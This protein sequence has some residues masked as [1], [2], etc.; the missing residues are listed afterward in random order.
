MPKV[1]SFDVLT[2]EQEEIREDDDT[3]DNSDHGEVAEEIVADTW[4]LLEHT[5]N[6]EYWYDV[7]A[8]LGSRSTKGEVKSAQLHVGQDYPAEGRFRIRKDQHDSLVR[9]DAQATAWYFF[10]VF[11]NS[12]ERIIIQRR[13]PSTVGRIVDELGGWN[14][15]GHSEFAYE[16]KMPLDEV[17]DL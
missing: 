6:E 9:S 3:S 11:D 15:S 14:R 7:R 17:V 4:D 12:R 5:P 10:V 16:Y 1:L 8:D 2:E 13:R